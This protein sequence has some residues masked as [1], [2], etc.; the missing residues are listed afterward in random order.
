MKRA[1]LFFPLLLLLFPFTAN[2]QQPSNDC[3]L[4]FKG[5]SRKAV[6][7]RTTADGVDYEVFQGG[8]PISVNEW[9]A[10]TCSLDVSVPNR[11]PAT[12]PIDGIETMTVTLE[13]F[14]V[15][16][17]FE[18]NSRPRDGK[19]NDLHLEIA[20]SRNWN[21]RHVIVEIPPGAEFCEARNTVW[22][23]KEADGSDGDSSSDRHIFNNPK[24][25]RVTGYVFL[26]SA[27]V[28]ASTTLC[29][30]S[31]G[32]GIRKDGQGTKVRG[33][34]EIHPVLSIEVVN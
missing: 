11:I 14:L 1:L 20:P 31:G 8:D 21:T 29:H 7:N 3:S 24:K 10:L 17:K 33:L 19:D 13:G 12:E 15:G 26:D 34:W 30:S 2:P 9:F 28:G 25:V 22:R 6:K 18:R 32:R 27:H 4:T 5:T 16:F 23:L